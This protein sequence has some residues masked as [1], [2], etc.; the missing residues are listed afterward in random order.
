MPAWDPNLYL[1]YANERA[2]PAADLI[3]QIHLDAP[4]RIV[5]LGCGPGNST[6]QLHQRWP[7]A[8]ITGLDHSQEMLAEAKARHPGW[9]W[10]LGDIEGWKPQPAV[11]LIFSNAAFHWVPGHATLFRSLIGGVSPG[12]A[13]AA[14]MPNN[15]HSAAHSVIQQVA[16]NGDPRWSKDLASAAG[17]FTVQPAAFYYDVLRKHAGRVDIWETEYQHVMDGPKAIFDWIRSTGMRPYLDRLADEELRQLFEE[18]CLE[19]FQEAYPPND[20]GKVLFPFR[21][22]FIVAYR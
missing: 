10:L 18:M 6:E 9:Q 19:G 15:F 1:K 5:D 8:A 16:A 11:D 21:R 22:M 14:Q 7:Q 13:L 3:A 17:T 4:M 20:Q 2:R 12:G